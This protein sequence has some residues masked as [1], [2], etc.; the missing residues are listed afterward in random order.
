MKKQNVILFILIIISLFILIALNIT[1]CKNFVNHK[2]SQSFFNDISKFAEENKEQIFTI[3]EIAYFSSSD[4]DIS[5]NS[6]ST[7]LISNLFQYTDIAIFLKPVSSETYTSRNT[8]KSV[9]LTNF[10]YS[11][12]PQLGSPNLYYKSL[13][14]FA[15][16]NFLEDDLIDKSITFNTTSEDEIDYST[17]ILYNNCAN[18]I[19]LC[20]VNSGIKKDYTLV[21]DISD[22][23]HNGSLLKNCGVTL[24]SI[25]CG[26]SFDIHIVNNL[27]EVF[28]CPVSINIPL[29]TESNTIYDGNLI[30]K[31]QPSYNFV[32]VVK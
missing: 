21:D 14:N 28:I 9:E 25:S 7:F 15:T 2:K 17:P 16:P 1:I 31:E 29:S 30:I 22:V 24:N 6:N 8:L 27:D 26:I 11:Y 3:D 12:T 13:N 20:Y 4:A 10:K 23:I 18:P 32:K 5:I 19:T